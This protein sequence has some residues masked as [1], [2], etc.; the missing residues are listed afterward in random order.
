MPTIDQ[1]ELD[2]LHAQEAALAEAT[3]RAEEAE[4]KLT[5]AAL[6]KTVAEAREQVATKVAEA[7]KD[8]PAPMIA[9]ITHQVQADITESLPADID[10]RITAAVEA[11]RTYLASV[12]ESEGLKGFGQ[13][14]AESIA[15]AKRTHNAFGRKIQEV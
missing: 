2:R 13:A 3:K 10:A 4:A 12:T 1:A 6:A 14:V 11:E 9:R 15:P 5:E 8:L 7:A